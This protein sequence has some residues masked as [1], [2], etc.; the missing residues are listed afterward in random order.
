MKPKASSYQEYLR[1]RELLGLQ[2][3]LSDPLHHDEMLFIVIH[4]VY[5]LWFREMIH[6]IGEVMSALGVGKVRR[7]TRLYRRLIEIQR[8]LI[9]QIS[10][11]ETMTP[12]DF[13][14]FRDL[15]NPASGFQSGQFRELEF[16]SGMKDPSLLKM[17]ILDAEARELLKQ[18]LDAPTLLDAFD[19]LLRARG[20]A[21]P[22]PGAAGMSEARLVALKTVYDHHDD[23]D[24]LYQLS[25]A[26]IEYDENFQLWRYHHIR[27]V[28]RMIGRKPGTGGSEGVG[29]LA[30]TLDKRCFPELWEVRTRLSGGGGYG[31]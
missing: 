5:E 13:N 19:E 11:L 10:V 2:Q 29:Y 30:K 25:E 8:V 16:L 6:E 31:A 14:E 26:M 15:L 21:M 28:E 18:R 1:I 17:P 24:D 22:A 12:S 27:M 23:H 20:F 9:Q 3:R 4:Q 7:A